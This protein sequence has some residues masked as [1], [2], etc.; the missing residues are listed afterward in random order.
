M[1]S[2]PS[3]ERPDD[4]RPDEENETSRRGVLDPEKATRRKIETIGKTVRTYCL[5][6]HSDA[7]P[8]P[9]SPELRSALNELLELALFTDDEQGRKDV[10]CF[11]IALLDEDLG[12]VVASA[13]RGNRQALFNLAA[14]Y[15]NGNEHVGRN[16]TNAAILYKRAA[17]KG[18]RPAGESYQRLQMQHAAMQQR[19]EHQRRMDLRQTEAGIASERQSTLRQIAILFVSTVGSAAA[20]LGFSRFLRRKGY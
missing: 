4:A 13:A 6:N 5:A 3:A 20:A 2:E 12:H 19:M 11:N 1:L 10:L 7:S 18:H 14:W 9:L 8:T 17:M 15:E 16:Q